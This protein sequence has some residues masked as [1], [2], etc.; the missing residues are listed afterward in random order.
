V[1]LIELLCQSE[2][3]VCVCVQGAATLKLRVAVD[4]GTGVVTLGF[5]GLADGWPW[6]CCGGFA[7]DLG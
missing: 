6:P 2:K 5:L 3:S 1:T 7:V 4:W